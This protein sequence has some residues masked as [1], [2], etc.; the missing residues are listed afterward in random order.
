MPVE[1]LITIAMA[2]YAKGAAK[3][4][5]QLHV[6]VVPEAVS[7]AHS[8]GERRQSSMRGAANKFASIVRTIVQLR[9]E[10]DLD[11]LQLPAVNIDKNPYC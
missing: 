8:T 11:F 2:S 3:K 4:P 9:C 6:R 1:D 5:L 7:A 10:Y